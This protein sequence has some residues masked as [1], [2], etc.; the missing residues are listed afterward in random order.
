MAVLPAPRIVKL[1]KPF[2]A[3]GRWFSTVYL[4][5]STAKEGE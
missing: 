5:L 2:V 4:I 3:I 1:V